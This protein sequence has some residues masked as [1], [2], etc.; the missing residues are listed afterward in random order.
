VG[1]LDPT[2]ADFRA[3]FPEFER[4]ADSRVE[5]ALVGSSLECNA[6]QYQQL[7]SE[8]VLYLAAHRLGSSPFGQATRSKDAGKITIYQQHYER[9]QQLAGGGFRVI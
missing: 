7:Y 6:D 4:T 9:I 2:L 8:A 5:D 1:Q 3:R